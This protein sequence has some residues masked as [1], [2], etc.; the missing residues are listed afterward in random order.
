MNV[1]RARKCADDLTGIRLYRLRT[2]RHYIAQ[3]E[4]AN[5][6]I[7]SGLAKMGRRSQLANIQ[8]WDKVCVVTTWLMLAKFR[9]LVSYSAEDA[10]KLKPE[11]LKR[12]RKFSDL[13]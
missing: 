7:N 11:V 3:N 13:N 2:V 8:S 4:L 10:A 12:K 5:E 1:T 6:P 9:C